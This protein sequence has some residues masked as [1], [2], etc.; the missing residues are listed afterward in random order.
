MLLAEC[1]VALLHLGGDNRPISLLLLVHLLDDPQT[2]L[3]GQARHLVFE[4]CELR[5]LRQL[6]PPLLFVSCLDARLKVVILA[7]SLFATLILE[8]DLVVTL[9]GLIAFFLDELSVL[10]EFMQAVLVL[11]D[12]V[13]GSRRC[14]QYIF[15]RDLFFGRLVI[16]N[17]IPV[18][19]G[20]I[21]GLRALLSTS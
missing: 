21:P 19:L 8:L 11:V 13:Q 17:I 10:H 2:T 3:V 9:V 15:A 5:L 20:M 18:F 7:L 14:W 12:L 6:L 16:S 4:V 1:I